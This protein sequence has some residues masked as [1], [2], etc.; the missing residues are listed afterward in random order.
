LCGNKDYEYLFVSWGSTSQILK[1]AIEELN[2]EKIAMLHFP[3]V[4]PL[5]RK[6]EDYLKKAKKVIFVEQNA[7]GQFADL[8]RM[9]FGIDTSNRILKYDGFPFSVEELKE[10]IGEAL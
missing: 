2:N 5:A 4:Y 9:E 3:Q 1:E 6:V 7:T 10:K 8:V